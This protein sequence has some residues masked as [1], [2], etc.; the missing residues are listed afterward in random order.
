LLLGIFVR[1]FI[2]EKCKEIINE[3]IE[4]NM[5]ITALQEI[6]WVGQGKIVKKDFT[7][8]YSRSALRTG[9]YGTRFTVQ[10]KIMK[11]IFEFVPISERIC[12]LRVKGKF[13]NTTIINVPMP[14]EDEDEDVIEGVYSELSQECDKTPN[15]DTLLIIGDFNAEI[16]RESC[17]SKV[18]GKFTHHM[19]TSKNGE[20]LCLFACLQ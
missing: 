7:L 18:A 1:C 11:Y 9:I 8:F 19:R 4:Y 5:H 15:N 14:T 20:K 2:Q 17:N 16:G 13:L 10:K 3:I 12:K 6:R